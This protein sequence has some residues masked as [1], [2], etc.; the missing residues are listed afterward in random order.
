MR[1]FYT[2]A[3]RALEAQGNAD[4][5][6]GGFISS[7]P[8]PNG[9]LNNL[10]ADI[11][12]F[13]IDHNVREV[14]GLALKNV[15]G[16][17][18][19]NVT[20]KYKYPKGF[21][22]KIEVAFVAVTLDDCNR[23]V[24]EQIANVRSLPVYAEFHEAN[25]VSAFAS[26]KLEIV[27][28]NETLTVYVGLNAIASAVIAFAEGIDEA[29]RKNATIDALVDAINKA[30]KG[31]IAEKRNVNSE[32]QL[33]IEKEVGGVFTESLT[34]TNATGV[35]YANAASFEG[36]EDNSV[37][38]GT[39]AKD[40]YI[41]VWFKK[42]IRPEYFNKLSI[43]ELDLIR[44]KELKLETTDNIVFEIEWQDQPVPTV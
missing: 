5:S 38:I 36:G 29:T 43:E 23:A 12:T 40:A 34:L 3:F 37:N 2:N 16:K 6:L 17:A 32:P 20:F 25:M 18:V 28:Q 44:E 21:S 13:T 41:G 1:F 14:K 39:L 11:S 27:P 15:L 19:D 30:N 42:T 31:F 8:V 26:L 24:M 7:S 9:Q 35:A 10:F 22:S 4:K 33:Y